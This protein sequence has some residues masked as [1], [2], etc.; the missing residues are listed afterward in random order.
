MTVNPLDMETDMTMDLHGWIK[1]TK[2]V[3]AQSPLSHVSPLCIY[4]YIKYKML[5]RQVLYWVAI[6]KISCVL[7]SKKILIP[8]S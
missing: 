7:E 3:S 2:L 6:E 5:S 8:C 4:K 1:S